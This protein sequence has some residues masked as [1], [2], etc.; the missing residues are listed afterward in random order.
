MG[1]STIVEALQQRG[2]RAVLHSIITC[3]VRRGCEPVK[4]FS[5]AIAPDGRVVAAEAAIVY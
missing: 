1:A 3:D 4:A 5:G 2:R